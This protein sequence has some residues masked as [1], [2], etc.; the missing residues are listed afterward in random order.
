MQR[1]T[2]AL[3]HRIGG[4]G[5]GLQ[6]GGRIGV[7]ATAFGLA[8]PVVA[9]RHLRNGGLLAASKVTD[10]KAMDINVAV[11]IDLMTH[12]GTIEA[13][14]IKHICLV[15]NNRADGS[16]NPR[17]DSRNVVIPV[18]R[19]RRCRWRSGHWPRLEG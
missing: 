17:G 2:L 9:R 14:A 1:Q 18:Q 11:S 6:R 16:M 13:R 10:I 5:G 8:P 4:I 19:L 7:V 3:R 15:G 12:P